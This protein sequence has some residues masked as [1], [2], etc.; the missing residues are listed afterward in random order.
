M[1]TVLFIVNHNMTIY[2]FRKELVEC[3]IGE[4]YRVVVILPVTEETKKI[5]D[6]GC[7]VIDVPVER[8]GTNPVHDFKLF[9]T[10]RKIVKKIRPDVVL[11]Y[12]IKPN[13]YGGLAAGSLKI[14]YIC[15]VTGLGVAIEGGGILKKI[16]L[17][18]YKK[19]LS[20][21]EKVF[22]QNAANRKVFEEAKIGGGRYELVN[23]SGVNI[24]EFNSLSFPDA[25]QPAEFVFISRVQKAKGIDHF[26]EMAEQIKKKYPDT[27]FHILGFCEEDYKARLEELTKKGVICYHGMLQDIRPVLERCQ[28][29]V[30]PSFHEGMSNVCM[31]AAAAGR[32]VI[33]SNISGCR[34]IVEEGITGFLVEPGNTPDL[35]RAVEQFLNLRYNKKMQMGENG[36]MKMRK[37]FNRKNVVLKYMEEIKKITDS[38]DKEG[39]GL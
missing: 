29:L 3:L 5:A 19:G 26:L 2:N 1:K 8:R 21:V 6:L 14:P 28:C 22:F 35:V 36:R 13:V 32:V 25:D 12:T 30:H 11:T 27:V 24:E 10:Y 16:S 4:G 39:T 23:G 18:L 34:E 20:R 15:T 38:Y 31:E 17:M 37:E 9:Q 7:E 33:A